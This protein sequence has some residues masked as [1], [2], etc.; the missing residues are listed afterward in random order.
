MILK[1]ETYKYSPVLGWSISRYETFDK[2][3]RMY[4]YT[5]YSKFVPDIPLYK[6]KQL[7]ALTSSP[8]EIGNVVHDIIEAFLRRLQADDSSIDEGRFFEYAK[9][10]AEEYFS[11]KTLLEVYY[12]HGRKVSVADAQK[13]IEQCLTNLLK[14]PIYNWIYMKALTNKNNWMIEPP[15]YGET[16]L[17][18][19]KAYC[20]MD[21]LFPVEDDIYI[22]DWKT[23]QKDAYKHSNQLIGY[24]AAASSNFQLQWNRIFPKIIYLYPEFSEFELKLSERELHAF[25]ETVQQQTKEMQS[26]CCN[27]EQNIP[28]PIDNFPQSPSPSVCKYCNFQELCFP[29][30]KPSAE[31]AETANTYPSK[32]N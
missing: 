23:G 1:Y 15:G 9:K 22:L 19:L 14:S 8:L 28:L 31:K 18:D 6:I 20:K 21:F 2:C 4:F 7:K 11:T 30:R 12:G 5:Y 16:R 29:E 17:N 27:V 26:Y 24:A 3:K 10:K 25:F 32:S 13:K